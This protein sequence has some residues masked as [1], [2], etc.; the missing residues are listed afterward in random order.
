MFLNLPQHMGSY[1]IAI[2]WMQLQTRVMLWMHLLAPN[3]NLISNSS[4]NI[5][6]VDST[7][8]H[9]Y[10]S[11]KILEERCIMHGS[12]CMYIFHYSR[13]ICVYYRLVYL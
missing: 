1:A 5:Y 11:M 6:T 12:P 3:A 13:T 2:L 7:M 9:T 10:T 8:K 4:C